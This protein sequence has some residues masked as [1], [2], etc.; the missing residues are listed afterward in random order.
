MR[1]PKILKHGNDPDCIHHEDVSMEN[2]GTCRC[3]GQVKDYRP[4][5]EILPAMPLNFE[6]ELVAAPQTKRDSSNHESAVWAGINARSKRA[7]RK[8]GEL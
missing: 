1:P 2:I 5:R 3:C 4:K 8:R 7:Y 6:P